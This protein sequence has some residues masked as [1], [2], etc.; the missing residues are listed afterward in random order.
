MGLLERV[1]LLDS[2]ELVSV[3]TSN[4]NDVGV[5]IMERTLKRLHVVTLTD[6]LEGEAFLL[7]PVP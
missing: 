5:L 7:I 2:V 4:D 1:V 6:C 3:F